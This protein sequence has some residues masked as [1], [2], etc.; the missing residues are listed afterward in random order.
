MVH[1]K[2]MKSV[3]IKNNQ[4]NSIAIKNIKNLNKFLSQPNKN[5]N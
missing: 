2:T 4:N 3:N 1:N 5:L